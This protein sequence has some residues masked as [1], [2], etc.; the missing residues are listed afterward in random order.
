MHL[1]EP[2]FTYGACGWFTKN[3]ERTGKFMQTGNTDYLQK[4]SG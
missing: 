3:K 2:A 1:K 4:W